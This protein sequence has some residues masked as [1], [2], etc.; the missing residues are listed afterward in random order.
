MKYTTAL[1][2]LLLAGLVSA[3]SLPAFAA[4][5]QP[6]G[7]KWDGTVYGLAAGMSGDITVGGTTAPL[8]TSF[9]TILDNL[10]FGFMGQLRAS[11]G[12]WA[13]NTDVIYMG[14][15]ASKGGFSADIDQWCIEPTVGYR[16]NP[17]FEWLGGLRYN[18]LSGEIRGPGGRAPTGSQDWIDPIVGFNYNLP[19]NSA[20]SFHL[21]ADIGGFGVGSDLTWQAYPSASWRFS[22]T[23]VFQMGYRWVYNDYESGSGAKYFRYDV[24]SQGPQVGVTFRF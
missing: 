20:W 7:W 15:G 10:E 4:D 22:E 16:V 17:S 1:K 8:D 13:V 19:T 12:P 9:G 23:G 3:L 18:S 14:L 5:N 11:K 21:R 6:E 2:T 24:T